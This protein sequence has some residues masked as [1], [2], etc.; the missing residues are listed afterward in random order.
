MTDESNQEIYEK[1]RRDLVRTAIKQPLLTKI[2]EAKD[3]ARA[4]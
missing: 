4:V 2:R 3:K 1:I